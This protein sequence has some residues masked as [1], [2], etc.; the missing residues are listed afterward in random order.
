MAVIPTIRYNQYHQTLQMLTTKKVELISPGFENMLLEVLTQIVHVLRNIIHW[1]R[2]THKP[3]H[4]FED[5]ATN[6]QSHK[7]L[8]S[9]HPSSPLLQKFHVISAV[10]VKQL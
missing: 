8:I 1:R 10:V 3:L 2:G 7:T 6:L 9:M 4:A 5:E